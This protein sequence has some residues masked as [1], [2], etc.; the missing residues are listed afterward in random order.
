[1]LFNKAVAKFA[2]S[3]SEQKKNRRLK[4]LDKKKPDD[5]IVRLIR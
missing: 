3:I 4:F 5:K 2:A 1:M